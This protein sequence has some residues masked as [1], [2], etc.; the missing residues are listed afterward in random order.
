[1]SILGIGSEVKFSITTL[2][3]ARHPMV[4]AGRLT[5]KVGINEGTVG[6]LVGW[7]GMEAIS[8]GASF[9]SFSAVAD[10]RAGGHFRP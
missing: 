8:I 1:M 7:F 5:H 3:F 6:W 10:A 4:P 9:S 2:H